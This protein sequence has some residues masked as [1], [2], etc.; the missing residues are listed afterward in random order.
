MV[1]VTPPLCH[2][3]SGCP[4]VILMVHCRSCLWD[5]MFLC[6]TRLCG[7][8]CPDET[9]S[10]SI[11]F[12]SVLFFTQPFIPSASNLPFDPFSFCLYRNFF[13]FLFFWRHFKTILWINIYYIYPKIQYWW[14]LQMFKCSCSKCCP[15]FF[16]LRKWPWSTNPNELNCDHAL[17]SAVHSSITC[18]DNV[19]SIPLNRNSL[20]LWPSA[21]TVLSHVTCAAH[22]LKAKG[23]RA[24][25]QNFIT[26]PNIC[27]M[28]GGV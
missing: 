24:F 7:P 5:N 18:T 25:N 11:F 17:R 28:F 21:R 6:S 15:R 16:P 10:Y 27:E 26:T 1:R 23:R 20:K 13:C 14:A 8:V 2:R 3:V 19:L 4:G 22:R 9:Q 12:F